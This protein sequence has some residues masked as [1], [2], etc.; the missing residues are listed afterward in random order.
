MQYS[1]DTNFV[2][3]FDDGS[4]AMDADEVDLANNEE[5]MANIRRMRKEIHHYKGN[6][7]EIRNTSQDSINSQDN[8]QG[9][10]N[11]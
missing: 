5:L 8:H 7:E 11:F 4:M 9:G 2:E 3:E 1:H 6:G 10:N